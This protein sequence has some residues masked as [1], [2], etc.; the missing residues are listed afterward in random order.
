MTSSNFCR[1]INIVESRVTCAPSTIQRRYDLGIHDLDREMKNISIGLAQDL[2]LDRS[3]IRV[4]VNRTRSGFATY[5][6]KRHHGISADMLERKWG[7]VLDK[8]NQNLQYTTLDNLISSVK[9]LTRSY[10]EYLLLHRLC[11]LNCI[12]IQTHYL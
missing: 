3:I 1:Y 12:F 4:R 9:T 6:Y 8:A 5:T 7:I 2:M 10:R 11:R